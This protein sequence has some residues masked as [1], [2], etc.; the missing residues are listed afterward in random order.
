MWKNLIRTG[1]TRGHVVNTEEE[2][3]T[4][5]LDVESGSCGGASSAAYR[6]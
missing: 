3:R 6:R 4:A 1:D 5:F 2:R